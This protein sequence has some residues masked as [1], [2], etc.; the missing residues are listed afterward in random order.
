MEIEEGGSL[1]EGQLQYLADRFVLPDDVVQLRAVARAIAAVA[2]QV[3]VGHEGHLQLD[4]AGTRAN[5]AAAARGVEG[6]PA[7]GIAADFRLGKGSEKLADLV[8]DT[9]VSRGRR[10]RGLA[11]GRLVDLDDRF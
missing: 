1:L 9:E 8:K 10:A 3:R 4:A 6:E 7:R 11:D 2:G 5:F